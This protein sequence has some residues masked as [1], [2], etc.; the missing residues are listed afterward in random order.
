MDDFDLVPASSVSTPEPLPISTSLDL[1]RR[2]TDAEGGGGRHIACTGSLGKLLSISLGMGMYEKKTMNLARQRVF[3][4][5]IP[6]L[7]RAFLGYVR[8]RVSL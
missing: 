8:C 5:V 4:V 2:S 1:R 6:W 3:T 7:K